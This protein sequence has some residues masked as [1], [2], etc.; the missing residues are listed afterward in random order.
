MKELPVIMA[1]LEIN[2][3]HAPSVE[4]AEEKNGTETLCEVVC[5]VLRKRVQ[6]TCQPHESSKRRCSLRPMKLNTSHKTDDVES[7]YM[8]KKFHSLKVKT[9]ATIYEEPK[10]KKNGTVAH[11][12]PTKIRRINFNIISKDKLRK[13][14]AKI[15]KVISNKNP[16]KGKLSMEEFLPRLQGLMG[17]SSN[18]NSDINVITSLEN[19]EV[20]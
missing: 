11:T 18:G 7:Y 1:S 20:E 14:K 17:S 4:T 9:L 19:C 13:R 16:K 3:N 8:S 12:G 10:V 2:D 5:R 6:S 15:K